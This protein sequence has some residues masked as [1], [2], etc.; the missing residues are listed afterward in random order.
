[1][2]SQEL[3]ILL[4]ELARR[5]IPDQRAFAMGFEHGAIF[6]DA[7]W[8]EAEKAL[9]SNSTSDEILS[10]CQGSID[11]ADSDTWRLRRMHGED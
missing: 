5:V 7:S 4:K 1:M 11:G 8:S 9:G 10:Y 3:R 6:G 2:M